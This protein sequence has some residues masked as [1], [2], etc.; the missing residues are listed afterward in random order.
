MVF[1]PSAVSPRNDRIGSYRRIEPV[2]L[3]HLPC[4]IHPNN[5]PASA[6]ASA[7]RD[8]L[9]ISLPSGSGVETAAL[10]S[11]LQYGHKAERTRRFLD[12]GDVI[13]YKHWS[14]GTSAGNALNGVK[15]VSCQ[16]SDGQA[17]IC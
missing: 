1:L 2:R 14:Y 10:D 16:G 11:A 3:Q 7:D 6:A 9:R 12:R 17:L 5:P 13:K 4:R 8:D 15:N